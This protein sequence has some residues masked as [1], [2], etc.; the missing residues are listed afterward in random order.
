MTSELKLIIVKAHLSTFVALQCPL[1]QLCTNWCGLLQNC[2]NDNVR[3]GT[4]VVVDMISA[5]VIFSWMNVFDHMGNGWNS[6]SQKKQDCL[7]QIPQT[8]WSS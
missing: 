5:T 7:P 8:E 4:S 2:T 3:S 6:G 1:Q